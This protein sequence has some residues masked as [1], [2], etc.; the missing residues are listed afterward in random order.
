MSKWQEVPEPVGGRHWPRRI[1]AVFRRFPWLAKV[2]QRGMRLVRPRFTMG[3]VG[4][5]MD[6][7]GTRVLLVEHVFHARKPWGLPGG[8]MNRGE[9]PAQTVEREFYEETGLRVR[10]IQPMLIERGRLGSHMEVVFLV[11]LDG[12]GQR[13][14]LSD[15][16][17]HWGWVPVDDLPPLKDFQEQAIRMVCMMVAHEAMPFQDG[18]G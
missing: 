9:N 18:G 8:W 3:V 16:L 1:A 13:I 14:Q 5:L 6:A 10:A 11:R 7:T 12:F 2:L 17:L 15:E 4:V